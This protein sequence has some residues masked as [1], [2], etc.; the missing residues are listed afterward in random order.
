[1][2]CVFVL[3]FLGH[4]GVSEMGKTYLKVPSYGPGPAHGFLLLKVELRLKMTDGC[5]NDL[6]PYKDFQTQHSGPVSWRTTIPHSSVLSCLLQSIFH[7]SLCTP[8][9]VATCKSCRDNNTPAEKR[10][11]PTSAQLNVLNGALRGG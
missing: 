5:S 11:A 10:T 1:M 9:Q 2:E 6:V 4:R 8:E 7:P 3:S